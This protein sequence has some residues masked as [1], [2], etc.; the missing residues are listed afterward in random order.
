MYAF[1]LTLHS[2]EQNLINF[3]ISFHL[4]LFNFHTLKKFIGEFF[5][6]LHFIF[7]KV[8]NFDQKIWFRHQIFHQA[9]ECTFSFVN[10]ILVKLQYFVHK[11]HIFFELQLQAFGYNFVE[12]QI[13]VSLKLNFLVPKTLSL[14]KVELFNF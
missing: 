1:F 9:I 12:A 3:V 13:F 10:F 5:L 7:V 4:S 14:M 6:V 8:Q 11:S 2:L